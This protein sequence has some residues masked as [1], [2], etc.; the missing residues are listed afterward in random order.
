LPAALS[1]AAL[2]H[3]YPEMNQAGLSA[4]DLYLAGK[5]D[6]EKIGFWSVNVAVDGISRIAS[7]QLLCEAGGPRARAR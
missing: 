4:R 5:F 6:D 3:T 7:A 2:A 1:G